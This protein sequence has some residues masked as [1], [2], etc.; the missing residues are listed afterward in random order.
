MYYN[1]ERTLNDL[2]AWNPNIQK[3]FYQLNPSN[4]DEYRTIY[5]KWNPFANKIQPMYSNF[6]N[7]TPPDGMEQ[8]N[9]RLL[10]S[11]NL[12]QPTKPEFF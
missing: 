3:T 9:P 5:M 4:K 6:V 12:M 2:K 10:S 1:G 8:V 11:L 7:G